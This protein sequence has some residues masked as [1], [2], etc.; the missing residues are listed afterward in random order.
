MFSLFFRGDRGD[1]RNVYGMC[2]WFD[3]RWVGM[4]RALWECGEGPVEVLVE[5]DMVTG[6]QFGL[7]TVNSGATFEAGTVFVHL[8]ISQNITDGSL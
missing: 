2:A 4:F 7:K 8:F 6:T 1:I 3:L 5:T